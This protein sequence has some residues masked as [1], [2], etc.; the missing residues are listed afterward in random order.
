M[1]LV[2]SQFTTPSHLADTATNTTIY[3]SHP[4]LIGKTHKTRPVDRGPWTG[5]GMTLSGSSAAWAARR[6]KAKRPLASLRYS[7]AVRGW[8]AHRR[9]QGRP[10][11]A[12]RRLRTSLADRRHGAGA[13]SRRFR[14]HACHTSLPTPS[15]L[16]RSCRWSWGTRTGP[17][18]RPP[19]PQT[20]VRHVSLQCLPACRMRACMPDVAHVC[21]DNPR[22]STLLLAQPAAPRTAGFVCEDAGRPRRGCAMEHA[23][24][25]SAR[26]FD[27]R[28]SSLTRAAV[29][30]QHRKHQLPISPRK[31]AGEHHL[32]LFRR[33]SSQ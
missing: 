12:P 29:R 31:L 20:C 27:T 15:R 17:G 18:R 1:E 21:T 25:A 6:R 26:A 32:R 3:P 23:S 13:R 11:A 28:L 16:S 7:A 22:V 30:R 24:G 9:M 33:N 2:G 10:A 5:C 8:G 19:G 4:N 14:G